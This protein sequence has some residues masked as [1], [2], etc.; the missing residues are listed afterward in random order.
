[1]MVYRELGAVPLDVDIKSHVLTYFARLCL[2]DNTIYLVPF[3]HYY[4]H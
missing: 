4:I 2:E 1:M 3:I